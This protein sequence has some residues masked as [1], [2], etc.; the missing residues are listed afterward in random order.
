M[1]AYVYEFVCMYTYSVYI[2]TYKEPRQPWRRLSQDEEEE[3][4]VGRRSKVFQ[5]K[6]RCKRW[7]DWNGRAVREKRD[8][9]RVGVGGECD[10]ERRSGLTVC[11]SRAG[12]ELEY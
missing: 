12:M 10:R 8:S 9:G 11:E 7:S 6:Q 2:Y 5:S 3:V 4:V 1:Y